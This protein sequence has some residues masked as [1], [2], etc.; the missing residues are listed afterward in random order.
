MMST[1][2]RVLIVDQRRCFLRDVNHGEG[3][4]VDVLFIEV[5]ENEFKL[6]GVVDGN[7]C[8]GI[9]LRP[10]WRCGRDW[11]CKTCRRAEAEFLQPLRGLF[12]LLVGALGRS[13]RRWT[14]PCP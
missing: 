1:T 10:R 8:N 11:S 2:R 3:I 7:Q 14:R 9:G 5:I 4:H 13:W 6:R 12:R